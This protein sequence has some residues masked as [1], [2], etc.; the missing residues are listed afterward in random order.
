MRFFIPFSFIPYAKYFK[1]TFKTTLTSLF[2]MG[3]LHTLN[4]ATIQESKWEQG[5]TL[6][7]FFEKNAIPLKTYYD[8]PTEDKELADEIIS[9]S[10]Y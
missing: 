2:A 7:T 8:L 6:L 9:G 5:Q 10:T 4:A 3:A 1:N